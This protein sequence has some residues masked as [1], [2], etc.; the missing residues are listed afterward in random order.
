MKMA[1][2]EKGIPDSAIVLDYA[3]FRTFD[4]IIRGKEIFGQSSFI[5]ISQPFHNERALYI[6]R[7]YGINALPLMPKILQHVMGL[8]PGSERFWPG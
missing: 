2:I 4:S 7:Q 5:I 1:L 8:K 3:G 6:A